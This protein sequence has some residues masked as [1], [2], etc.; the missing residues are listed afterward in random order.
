MD[1]SRITLLSALLL[2][3]MG[4][5]QA[6]LVHLQVTNPQDYGAAPGTNRS[7]IQL[8]PAE[9]APIRDAKGR[10]LAQDRRAFDCYLVLEEYEKGPAPLGEILKMPADDLQGEI[11]KIYQKIEKQVEHRP[12]QERRRLYLR[13]RRTPY[14]L[15]RDIPFEAALAIE[16]NPQKYAGALVRESLKRHYPRGAAA[17]HVLGYL[18]RA[19]SN[20]NEFRR[21]MQNHYFTE[22]LEELIGEDGIAQLY[23][24]GA[25]QEE[26]VGTA[27]IERRYDDVLRGRPGVGILEREPGTSNKT[28]TELKPPQPGRDVELTLDIDFQ[29]AVESALAVPNPA[30]A[31]VLD[32]WT[33]AVLA[34]A[35]NRTYNPNDFTPPGNPK[36]IGEA[37]QD[38]V[39]KPLISRAFG[40]HYQEGS[41]FKVV[42]S[43]AGL[44]E[45]KVRPDE[46]LPCRGKFRENSQHFGCWIWN[47]HRGMHG[48]VDLT[49]GLERSCNC[50]FFEVGRR[51]GWDAVV[52]WA[53]A[54]G[55]GS[56]TGIDLPGE[57]G[58][59]VPR[60]C[61][62]KDDVLSLAIGQHELMVSPLQAAVMMAAIAN[63]GKRVTP[64]LCRAAETAPPQPLGIS[65]STIAEIRKGLSRVVHGPHGTAH[66]TA[67][68]DL[69]VCGKTS[70]AQAGPRT[71]AWF[72]GYAPREKPE[73]VVV[74]FVEGGGHGGEAAAPIA[75]KILEI[76]LKKK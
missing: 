40:Q 75:A 70:S 48:E 23:R 28:L 4:G 31:V 2:L 56:R 29:A 8:I 52:R 45:K 55:Y 14:L 15:R 68:K 1:R 60:R 46:L 12:P 69:D 64:H 5:L 3:P 49:G 62:N 63:G 38:N 65:P 71:H 13:E 27:G 51:C 44:E 67:L 10:M 19:T 21:M 59:I 36:A 30:A 72:A 16:T 50:Y 54:L 32:P 43:V 20:E 33:G 76:F 6:R 61:G 18:G 34:L 74:V 9:R 42:T 37:L 53:L 57:A 17:C 11:E 7:S 47:E 39:G 41:I 24:R 73:A 22:G 58:G 66:A 26:L 35:S 25:F